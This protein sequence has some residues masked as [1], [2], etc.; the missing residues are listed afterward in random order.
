MQRCKG[1]SLIE[2]LVV[3]ILIGIIAAVAGLSLVNYT[4]NR[5]LR[6]AARVIASDFA[7][8]KE[9][10]I[11]E[12]TSYQITFVIGGNGYNINVGG[13]PVL[14]ATKSFAEFGSDI[15]IQN[16]DFGGAPQV[17]FISRGTI[18]PLTPPPGVNSVIHISGCLRRIDH[19]DN[20]TIGVE[21]GRKV[22]LSWQGCG[23]IT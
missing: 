3:V 23:D 22:G 1:F 9:R 12:N 15:I 10:A 19:F 16:A 20:A 7:L 8:C 6:S 21:T 5:N 2:L 17:N 4:I 18:S 11:S 14:V 13:P